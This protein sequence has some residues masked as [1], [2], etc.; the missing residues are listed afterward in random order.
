MAA[1]TCTYHHHRVTWVV[2]HLV[3]L[4][5]QTVV[6][7]QEQQQEEEGIQMLQQLLP[8]QLLWQPLL[9]LQR[10][11]QLLPRLTSPM[12]TQLTHLPASILLGLPLHPPQTLLF[13]TLRHP[14]LVNPLPSLLSLQAATNS[15]SKIPRLYHLLLS[16]LRPSLPLPHLTRLLLYHNPLP[17]PI[18]PFIDLPVHLLQLLLSSPQPPPPPLSPQLNLL[19]CLLATQT[20]AVAVLIHH[21]QVHQHRTH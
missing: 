16:R 3:I 14:L 20:T 17:K 19:Q 13:R 5:L 1:A 12:T 6:E 4:Q 9:L 2:T 15:H 8:E 18:W 7:D 11:P 21:S 10:L